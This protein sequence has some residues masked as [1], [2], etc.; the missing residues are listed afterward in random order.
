MRALFLSLLFSS[1][2]SVEA[3]QLD[4]YPDRKPGVSTADYD[5]A[6]QIL[7]ETYEQVKRDNGT[8]TY[9]DYWNLA[10]AFKRMD[11]DVATVRQFLFK[12][13][14]LDPEKFVKIFAK[15]GG[16][17]Q[18]W[19][20]YLTAAEHASVKRPGPP[21]AKIAP[22]AKSESV[23]QRYDPALI[24]A[25]A[26]IAADDQRYRSEVKVDM[27]AQRRLD[28]QNL[29]KI[30]RL[31]QKYGRYLG[32]DLVGERFAH[33]MWAVVQHSDPLTME[34]YLPVVHAAVREG[35]LQ[36]NMLKMLLDRLHALR[37]GYQIFGSQPGV[38]LVNKAMIVRIRRLYG[39]D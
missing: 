9:A 8:F 12:S 13:K 23:V 24:E 15:L 32:K 20:K 1:I 35:K 11:Q 26:Q 30:D 19:R 3:Q 38:P 28:L 37:D 18:S 6:K 27:E 36:A 2:L 33:V 39:L 21:T 5:M 14:E 31:Y 22:Q 10:I 17:E 4:Y 7:S 16:T 29:V 34:R 25:I